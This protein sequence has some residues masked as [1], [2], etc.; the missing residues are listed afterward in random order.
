MKLPN[1]HRLGTFT[2]L[3][4]LLAGVSTGGLTLCEAFFGGEPEAGEDFVVTVPAGNTV[5]L[6]EALNALG[7]FALCN[8]LVR[9]EGGST[10]PAGV[11][12]RTTR[13]LRGPTPSASVD[14]VTTS[15]TPPGRYVIEYRS[16]EPGSYAIGTIDLTVEEVHSDVTA[17][18]AVF[19]EGEFILVNQTVNFYGCCSQSPENDPIVQYKWWFNYNGNPS[20]APSQTTPGCMT[21]TTYG[22]PGT[23]NTRLVVRTESGL[24]A[25]DTYTIDVLAP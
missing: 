18:M 4:L 24:E 15:A 7:R 19:G 5:G 25:E 11:Y 1:R 8:S 12:A 2:A 21:T 10:I 6:A 16:T 22:T 3:A 17:C 23:K 14:L 9:A 13:D 20:S